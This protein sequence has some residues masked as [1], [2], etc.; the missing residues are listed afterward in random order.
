M[1]TKYKSFSLSSTFFFSLTFP[2]SKP[3]ASVTARRRLAHYRLCRPAQVGHCF[4]LCPCFSLCFLFLFFFHVA[5]LCLHLL[6]FY[7]IK[8]NTKVV[9]F[10]C[11]LS[12]FLSLHCTLALAPFILLFYNIKFN[13]KVTQINSLYVHVAFSHQN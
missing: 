1:L 9:F 3:N 10:C 7:D 6:F 12:L 4:S 5:H 8:F 2:T 13:T 11:S